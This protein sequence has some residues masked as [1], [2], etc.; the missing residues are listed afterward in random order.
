MIEKNS[1]S[2]RPG[3]SRLIITFNRVAADLGVG[4]GALPEVWIAVT[5]RTPF[6][7]A[8]CVVAIVVADARGMNLFLGLTSSLSFVG[9]HQ[10]TAPT[11][12]SAPT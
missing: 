4:L 8:L 12:R 9:Q 7:G 1:V 5:G 3:G 10:F 2:V 6:P 11:F